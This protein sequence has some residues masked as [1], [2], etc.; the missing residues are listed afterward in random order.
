MSNTAVA[1]PN[2]AD[3]MMFGRFRIPAELLARA[4]VQ[5]VTDSEAR[6][7]FGIRGDGNMD[8]IV[9]PYF[10]PFTRIR[11]TARLRRDTPEI[12]DGK[13]KRKYVCPYGD[14]RILYFPPGA[15]D[16]L[17]DPSVPIVLVE[18]EKSAL[19]LTAWAERRKRRMVFVALGG[20]W[21]WKAKTGK[22]SNANGKRID[23]TGPTPGLQYASIGRTTSVLLDAN[24]STNADVRYA[25]TMLVQQLQKQRADVVALD[26]PSVPDVNGPDDLIA[27]LGDEAMALIFDHP[28][29]QSSQSSPADWPD[30]AP[31]GNEFPAVS[32]FALDLIPP[33][34][35]PL[36]ADVSERMQTPLDYAAAAAIVSLAGCVNRRAIIR[37]KAEDTSWLVI[38]NLWG[39]II[40][41][42]GVM[43]SPILH[44]TT[45]PLTHIEEFWRAEFS[46]QAS[47]YETEKERADLARQAWREDYKRAMK[48]G[49][50]PPLQPDNSLRPP[51]Q[52]R[53]VLTDS[54]FEKMHEIL[55]ENS[56]GVLVIR[57][58]LTGWLAELDKQGREGERGFYL[59]GWNGNAGYTVD[60]IGRGSIYVPAVCISLLGNIQ[61]T[62]LR[63]FLSHAFD[64]GPS[65]DG[66]FQRFQIMV[67]PDPPR[68]WRLVDRPPNGIALGAAEKVYSVLANLSADDPVRMRFSPEAQVLFYAWWADL[69]N[70]IRNDATLSAPLVAHLAKYRSLMPK[71]AG[72]FELADLAAAEGA[73]Q[74]EVSVG[75]DHAR[76]AAAMCEYLESHARRVYACVTCVENQNARELAR[77]IQSDDLPRVFATRSVYLKG[78]T[79]LDTPERVRGALYV[80]EDA[81]WVRQMESVK[82]PSGGRP[83]ESWTVNPKVKRHEK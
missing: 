43:K 74:G 4:G 75:L 49:A 71:L 81:G 58:E 46:E 42:P 52:R 77:H 64:G 63:W 11:L 12:V 53:L 21:G 8:G 32:D 10:D 3:L 16:L 83:S 80:L 47:E 69:E 9:F 34:F 62:R 60:R 39:T 73:V 31:L 13:P 29:G 51:A 26:L 72:L 79:G 35:R 23:E 78:W 41:P 67:W 65:D 17:A 20:A 18:A 24:A 2:A 48:K 30:P 50:P 38:L 33:S 22:V 6:E 82:S 70:K 36:V 14:R 55:S 56:A 15:A 59:Q 25:R 45:L 19:A 7:N 61:P 57:D 27:L 5:R 76:Q 66:L 54:T 40:V 68:N 1:L 37:P 28:Q 44:A